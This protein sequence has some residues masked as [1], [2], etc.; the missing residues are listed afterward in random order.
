MDILPG[1]VA[2]TVLSD[3]PHTEE[4][5]E[6]LREELGL[7]DHGAVRYARWLWSMLTG[8]FGGNSLEMRTPIS[9]MVGR[10]LPV[11]AAIAAY[12]ILL[13]IIVSVPVGIL[14]AVRRGRLGDHAVRAISL[15]GIA[16]PHMWLALVLLLVLLRVFG[17]SP[18]IIYSRFV[19][20]PGEHLD[21][22]L[23]GC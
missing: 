22:G 23:G 18:P 13:S 8:E 15:G 9:D 4:M 3:T 14:A 17:W 21:A 2:L 20:N 1:D 7:N 19:E 11:T 6:V 5:R 10:E 16:I 12:T